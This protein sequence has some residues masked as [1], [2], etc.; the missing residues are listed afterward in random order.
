MY[1]DSKEY[2]LFFSKMLF[3]FPVYL[4]FRESVL[5]IQLSETLFYE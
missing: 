1:D 3:F 2:L 5:T 4:G